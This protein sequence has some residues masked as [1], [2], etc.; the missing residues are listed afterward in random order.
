MC[1]VYLF[2]KTDSQ[3]DHSTLRHGPF[4]I[5]GGGPGTYVWARIFFFGQYR[6]KVIFFA[7]PSGRIIFFIT[8]IYIVEPPNYVT[9]ATPTLSG[10]PLQFVNNSDYYVISHF[11]EIFN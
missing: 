4:D 3:S 9:T 10:K 5:L 11:F 7:G 2:H 8:E 6:S 1:N